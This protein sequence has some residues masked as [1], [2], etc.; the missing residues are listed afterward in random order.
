M[1]S[2]GRDGQNRPSH[3]CR[4][5]GTVFA[6][7][8]TKTSSGNLQS[9]SSSSREESVMHEPP[10]PV[11]P[12]SRQPES[13][14]ES[15]SERTM[16]SGQGELEVVPRPTVPPTSEMSFE[17][18]EPSTEGEQN[19]PPSVSLNTTPDPLL[20]QQSAPFRSLPKW[21]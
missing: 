7:N 18:Q 3:A 1:K 15:A 17:R 12:E 20:G 14:E 16:S 21:D 9:S 19:T 2:T 8:N 5:N 13:I 6:R 11:A 10:M 4:V